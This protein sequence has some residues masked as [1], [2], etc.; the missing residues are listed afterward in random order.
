MS[1]PNETSGLSYRD[2]GVDIE[3]GDA[4][5]EAIKP[6]AK[7]TLRDGVLGGIGGFG[8]LFEVPKRYKEPVLVSGTDGVGTKLKLAF[9]LNKHDTV[10]Q[11]LV[12]M[13]VNDILVQGA[14]PLF[15][16]DYF[17]CGKLDVATAATVVKGIAEGCEL[18]G[19]AL[20]GGE[21][22]EMPSMYPDGEY[23]LAGFAV[24]AVEKSKIIDGKSIVPGDV[25]LGL[26]SSGAHSNGYSLVRKIIEVAKPDLDA[27]FHG[28]PLR[29]VLMAPTRI[30]V[31]PLLALMQ[32]LTVKGM[33]HITGGGIVE[34]IPR[35][36]Q[37]HLTADIKQDAWTLPPLFQWLQ[38]HGKVADAEM[39]RVFNC[40]I[41]MAVIVSAADADAAVKHLEASGETVYRLGTI[42]ERKEGEAQTIVS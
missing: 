32:T 31:K 25:V 8:A 26:A 33:A 22:A 7:K 18:S 28:K 19:C 14:E 34:N 11:D 13:S 21:T 35:V 42:R 12:A 20:I 6:F 17:A 29:D 27:D 39:H 1:H 24:G 40:G 37:D 5:V 16:L 23:D 2:A 30:Y 10:G 36:L 4:L 3:A 9:T 15:F 41:G 38:E